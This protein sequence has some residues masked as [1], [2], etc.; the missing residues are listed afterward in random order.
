MIEGEV[1]MERTT[2][3][4]PIAIALRVP[5]LVDVVEAT[6]GVLHLDEQEMKS[7]ETIVSVEEIENAVIAVE[8][9][10]VIEALV[11]EMAGTKEDEELSSPIC[12]NHVAMRISRS[13]TEKKRKESSAQV[14]ECYCSI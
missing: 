10:I 5:P 1:P 3:D 4:V 6:V 2:G 14:Q 13:E 9:V 7:E 8:V 12:T 11:H